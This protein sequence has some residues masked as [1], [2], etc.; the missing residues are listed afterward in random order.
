MDNSLFNNLEMIFNYFGFI[1]FLS[2]NIEFNR[3]T[4]RFVFEIK[5]LYDDSDTN[6]FFYKVYSSLINTE[7]NKS[8]LVYHNTGNPNKK[9]DVDL[10][11]FQS[12]K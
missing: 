12:I 10:Y 3:G 4:S 6:K 2:I 5:F 11:I 7:I 8:K 9:N 1:H